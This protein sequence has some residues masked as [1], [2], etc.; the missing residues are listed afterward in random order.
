[1][2][3]S[4]AALL[5]EHAAAVLERAVAEESAKRRHLVISLSGA[6]AYG[7]PS[8]DSDLDLKAVHVEETARLLGLGNV[9]LSFARLEI[10]DGVEIDY[11]SNE[12]KPVLLGVL[13]GNGNYIERLLA[14]L[15]PSAAPELDA[16]RPL[17]RAALSRR[18]A[19][20]YLGFATSQREA[21]AKDATAKKLLYVLRTALTGAHALDT[22]EIVVDLSEVCEPYGFGEARELIEAKR[23]G[24]HVKLGAVDAARWQAQADRAIA[25][26]RASIDASP[27][28]AEPPEA[29]VRALSAWLLEARGVSSANNGP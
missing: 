29:S 15:A 18:I 11:T 2:S 16:L 7:F 10:V 22:G 17:V 9:T 28:P 4:W 26:L 21:F 8:P 19:G 25:R 27:L 1:M 14:T 5:G 13:H 6:H 24:E 20:H 23:K 12:L 3:T